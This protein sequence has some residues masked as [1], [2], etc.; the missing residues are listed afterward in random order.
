MTDTNRAYTSICVAA[1]REVWTVMIGDGGAPVTSHV[2]Q[3]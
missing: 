2:K 1:W 3:N